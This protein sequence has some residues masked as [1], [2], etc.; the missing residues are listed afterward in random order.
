M[1]VTQLYRNAGLRYLGRLCYHDLHADEK[2]NNCTRVFD[3]S[4]DE[5]KFWEEL[6]VKVT[7]RPTIS[8]SVHHGVEP[9]LGLMTR[10]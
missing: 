1:I 7:L 2:H 6:K 4:S 9:H 8:R 5:Y 10:Y 3:D